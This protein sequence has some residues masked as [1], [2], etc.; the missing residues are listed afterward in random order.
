MF[1]VYCTN[2]LMESAC[3]LNI[4]VQVYSFYLSTGHTQLSKSFDLNFLFSEAYIGNIFVAT[5]F[6]TKHSLRKSSISDT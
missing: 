4:V 1:E 6:I 3:T 2:S 5:D